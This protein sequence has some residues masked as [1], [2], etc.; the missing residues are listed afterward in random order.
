MVYSE[1]DDSSLFVAVGT[2]GKSVHCACIFLNNYFC[3]F[4]LS[5]AL[6]KYFILYFK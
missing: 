4:I 1:V 5:F 3:R 2:D 6:N